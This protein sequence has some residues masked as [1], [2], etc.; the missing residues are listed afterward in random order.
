MQR[1]TSSERSAQF[2]RAASHALARE[3]SLSANLVL[4]SKIIA[5]LAT[6]EF[7]SPNKLEAELGWRYPLVGEQLWELLSGTRW[8]CLQDGE[9]VLARAPR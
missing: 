6:S 5:T 8:M 3:L 9:V 2:L 7:S 4:P 1:D